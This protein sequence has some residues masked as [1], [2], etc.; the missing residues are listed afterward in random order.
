MVVELNIYRY[1]FKVCT[2][3]TENDMMKYSPTTLLDPSA[4]DKKLT[5]TCFKNST[6][7]LHLH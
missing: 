7:P 5:V 4:S 3:T 1:L 6:L 2:Y